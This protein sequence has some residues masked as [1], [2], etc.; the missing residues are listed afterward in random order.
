MPICHAIYHRVTTWLWPEVCPLCKSA[1]R[2]GICGTCREKT[3]ALIVRQPRCMQCGKPV[4]QMEQ[5]YCHDCMHTHHKYDRGVSLWLH[6]APVSTSIYQFKY[7]NQ[8]RYGILFAREMV[9]AYAKTIRRWAPDLIIPIPIHKKRRRQRGYNQAQILAKEVG[10]LL[11]IPVDSDSLV[12]CIPTN[13]QK[14]LG[15]RERRENLR[16]AFALRKEFAP[17][18]VVLLIDDIYTT[19]NTVDAAAQILK[20]GG[21]EKVYFLTISIGQG[22]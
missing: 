16:G 17:A 2:I 14:T 7:Q 20:N 18:A 3:A 15:H 22:Y 8:R 11:Q 4:R 6:T 21:V 19:G 9:N 10:R 1:S 5:E 13:P 12:R